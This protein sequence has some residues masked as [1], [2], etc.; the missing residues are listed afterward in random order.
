[1]ILFNVYL[2]RDECAS[3]FSVSQVEIQVVPYTLKKDG[4]IC[5]VIQ[6][7]QTARR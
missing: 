3:Y 7:G 2:C 5:K 4:L 1:M 6:S